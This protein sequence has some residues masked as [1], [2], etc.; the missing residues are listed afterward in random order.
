MAAQVKILYVN[1]REPVYEGLID[2]IEA[3]VTREKA[4]VSAEAGNGQEAPRIIVFMAVDNE[5]LKR[6]ASAWLRQRLGSSAVV[7][8]EDGTCTKKNT[9]WTL[10]IGCEQ[11]FHG[12]CMCACAGRKSLNS[13]L[14]MR[15]E[16]HSTEG[17]AGAVIDMLILSRCNVSIELAYVHCM[18]SFCRRSFFL[19]ICVSL[20]I[21]LL[22]ALERH[23]LY[24]PLLQHHK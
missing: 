16:R 9:F 24:S 13:S 23:C 20:S 5:P 1:N 17:M 15:I 8:A 18:L 12:P 22:C 3:I 2:N 4:I 10:F 11:S 7:S 6:R 14:G 21:R 19:E